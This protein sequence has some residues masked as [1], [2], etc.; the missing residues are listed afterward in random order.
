MKSNIRKSDLLKYLYSETDVYKSIEI[1]EALEKSSELRQEFA[2]LSNGKS[3][4]PVF[5][6][7]APLD[8]MNNILAYS[9]MPHY[10]EEIH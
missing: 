7:K 4:F 3:A 1:E 10:Y 9:R 6:K 2:L 8:A 5:L